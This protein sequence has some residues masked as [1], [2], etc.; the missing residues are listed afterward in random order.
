MSEFFVLGII[1]VIAS[2]FYI[3]NKKEKERKEIEKIKAMNIEEK[4]LYLMK[5]QLKVDRF[6]TSHILHL[7]LC[8]PTA[9]L[10]IIPWF[11][12]AQSNKSQR[13]ELEKLTDSI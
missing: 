2:F 10:W 13:D 5:M 7:L 12:I 11:L 8:V 4:K 9:G 1:G 3:K 6:K